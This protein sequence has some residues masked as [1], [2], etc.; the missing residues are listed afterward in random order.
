MCLAELLSGTQYATQ[1]STYICLKGL[2]RFQD[3]ARTQCV[4][5][6]W[7]VFHHTQHAESQIAKLSL[8]GFSVVT[9]AFGLWPGC[10]K[11]LSSTVLSQEETRGTYTWE[12]GSPK[13]A[14]LSIQFTTCPFTAIGT[15]MIINLSV[16]TTQQDS[17]SKIRMGTK[18]CSS[19]PGSIAVSAL[20]VALHNDGCVQ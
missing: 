4:T 17:D 12:C 7:H 18:R 2:R 16:R 6:D 8:Q 11:Q 10:T 3:L 13:V 14:L 15:C 9:T 19:S 20:L 5:T 1:T